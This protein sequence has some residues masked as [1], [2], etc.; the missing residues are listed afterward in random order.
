[1][2]ALGEIQLPRLPKEGDS[3]ETWLATCIVTAVRPL[4]APSIYAGTIVCR[5]R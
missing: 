4:P 5:L 2:R 1:M 3:L